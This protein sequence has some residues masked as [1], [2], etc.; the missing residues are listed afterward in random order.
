MLSFRRASSAIIAATTLAIS[1]TAH[2]DRSFVL[3][4]GIG[5][6]DTGGLSV[7]ALA[8]VSL[9]DRTWLTLSAGTTDA[10]TER[11]SIR[12]SAVQLGLTHRFGTLGIGIGGGTWGDAGRLESNDLNFDVFW[13][14]D[15][16]RFAID[17]ERRDIELT[18][19]F[20]PLDPVLPPQEVTASLDGD[21]IGA[22][23]RYR[24]KSNTS[25]SLRARQ[26]D[27][28]RDISRL[29][30]LELVRRISP[31]TLTLVGAL[32]ESQYTAAVDWEEGS[33]RFGLEIA[34]DR[35][36]V[37]ELD[38][39]SVT[40]TVLAPIGRRMDL[41][42]NFGVSNSDDAEGGAYGGLFLFFYGGG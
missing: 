19:V 17:Y 41:E 9:T 23:V 6:D 10:D 31:T 26:F 29:D 11:D 4:G 37:G 12:T 7:D 14:S 1:A 13:Q 24:T 36:I 38:V 33:Y 40:G 8:D 5:A 21:G 39:T 27:Y 2:A 34:R 35:L 20:R 32:R 30:S 42:V 3:G 28:S 22:N 18:L 16:W 15:T 25:F